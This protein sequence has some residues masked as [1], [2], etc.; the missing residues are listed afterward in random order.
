LVGDTQH[1]VP[2]NLHPH[3]FPEKAT[4]PGP[5]PQTVSPVSIVAWIA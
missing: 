2:E 4:A 3:L 5:N 1:T